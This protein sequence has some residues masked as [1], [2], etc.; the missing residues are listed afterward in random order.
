MFYHTFILAKKGPMARVWLAA[1][2]EKKLSKAVVFETDIK[3]SVESI[4]SPKIKMALRTSGHLLLGVVRIYSRKAKYLLADCSEAFV[5]I[6]MA[7][8]PGVVDLP[9]EGRELA[10]SA[11][12][13]PEVFTDLD[14]T[15]PELNDIELQA[16]FTLNQSRIEE[17]TMKEDVVVNNLLGDEGFGDI[18]FDSD[19]EKE[20]M[21]AGTGMEESLYQSKDL[22][23]ITLNETDVGKGIADSTFERSKIDLALDEPI[24]DDGFGG[25]G[26][27]FLADGFGDGLGDALVPGIDDLPPVAADE[28]P[29][30]PID[31]NIEGEELKKDDTSPLDN[32]NETGANT[33]NELTILQNEAE[34]F[35]LEP[36]EVVQKGKRSRRKRKLIVDEDKILSTDAI[37]AQL[38]DTTDVVK[39]ATLAPPTK[40]RMKL[41]T[42]STVE[43][44]FALPALELLASPLVEVFVINLT[45]KAANELKTV[46]HEAEEKMDTDEMDQEVPQESTSSGDKTQKRTSVS[47]EEPL[48]SMDEPLQD[49]VQ[50]EMPFPEQLEPEQ[51]EKESEKE[52]VAELPSS[53]M[54]EEQKMNTETE[55]QFENRRWTKR[56]SQLI[57]TLKREFNKKD[58]VNFN[59]LVQKN[60]RKQAAYKFYSCLLLSKDNT[61]N[62]KQKDLFGDIMLN[63]GAHFAA[64]C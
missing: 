57:H 3:S 14:M 8:R 39:H 60:T 56:T 16:Q 21:R 37:K 62:M 36:V 54:D 63:K 26:V 2:W 13:L 53:Q 9:E 34:A 43:Q 44:L 28:L 42:K 12:T 51:E 5:K 41:K 10:F 31:T 15:L 47:F 58:T 45:H 19:G 30:E 32:H 6:K 11:I 4:V 33:T 48:P 46:N 29:L 27:D 35:V 20:I 18:P 61:L 40:R 50:A 1:H 52:D 23:K 38:S 59:N 55:E 7:F 22:S 64:A 25:D 17:I 24:K 49:M